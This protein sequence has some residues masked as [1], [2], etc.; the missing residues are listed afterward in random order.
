LAPLS[1]ISI[2]FWLP[3]HEIQK[4]GFSA[5]NSKSNL[6]AP[7]AANSPAQWTAGNPIKVHSIQGLGFL[8]VHLSISKRSH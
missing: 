5:T 8:K 1:E 6:E 2:P 4:T 7:K 3:P